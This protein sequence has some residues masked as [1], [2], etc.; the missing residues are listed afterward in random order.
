M[1]KI[2]FRNHYIKLLH[3]TT[4][5]LYIYLNEESFINAIFS[6]NILR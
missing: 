1:H 6:G 4:V 5:I 2:L 3:E